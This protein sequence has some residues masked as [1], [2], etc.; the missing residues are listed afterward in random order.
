MTPADAR[1][2]APLIGFGFAALFMVLRLSRGFKPRPVRPGRIW[3]IPT[4]L[5]LAGLAVISRAPP[6][7]PEAGW[8]LLMIALGAGLGWQRGRLMTITLD[9]QTGAPMAKA[10]PAAMMFI[11]A[12]M[13][14]RSVM[15][16]AG[17][18]QADA[19]RLDSVFVTDLF[20]GFALGLVCG[21]RLEMWLRIRRMVAEAQTAPRIVA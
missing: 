1:Q 11:L 15:K 17:E 6:A 5:L 18:G 12:L 4:I 3:I 16:A 8:I 20:L 7:L 2:W 13:V 21:Q 9:S 14:G 19:W 10:S